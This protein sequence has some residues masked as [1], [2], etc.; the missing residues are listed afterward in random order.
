MAT[1][2]L[3]VGFVGLFFVL[4]AVRIILKKDGEFQ[5]TCASQSPFLNKEGVTCSVCGRDPAQC[6]NKP[7][8]AA[9]S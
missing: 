5:G 6:E 4:M 3:A 8:A 1:V 2:L 9:A 7:E